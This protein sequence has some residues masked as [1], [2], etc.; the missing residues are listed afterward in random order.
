MENKPLI[1]VIMS[2][3]NEEKYIKEALESILKQ[4]LGDFEIILI[5]DKSTDNTVSIIRGIEDERI[6]LVENE[7]NQGITVNLN[8]ALCMAQGKYIARMD[9]D[10]ISKPE[11]FKVQVDYLNAH[12]EIM[13]ISCNT[14]TF[15]EQE[16]ISD[17][18]GTPEEL[19]CRMLLRPVLAH[20][21]FML[22]RELFEQYGFSYDEHFRSAQDYDFAARVTRKH[23]I[24]VVPEVLL[25]Y[26][27]HKGQISQT[28]SLK[29]FGYADE[30]RARLLSELGIELEA[31][32]IDD[33]H[34]WILEKS[35]DTATYDHNYKLLERILS[36]NSQKNIYDSKVLKKV[37][38]EQYYQWMLRAD[39]YH[40]VIKNCGLNIGSY[41][42]VGKTAVKMV[43]SKIRRS[44]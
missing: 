38:H 32:E 6:H 7:I 41:F 18:H 40:Y 3:Y 1:S 28:P 34:Q 17:I 23:R 27:A 31:K 26:R 16:L 8:K 24:Y 30:I 36:A 21:G 5:D 4:T 14:T 15:G 22:R 13:L 25:M 11:R 20:P 29:Q 44:R 10:D 33:F 9:G 35:S 43:I 2:V 37:L 42:M 39:G 12:P 19:K